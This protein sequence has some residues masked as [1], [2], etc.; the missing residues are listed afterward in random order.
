MALA[1][2]QPTHVPAWKKLGLKLKN[3]REEA[4]G[5]LK[6]SGKGEAD[7]TERNQASIT[8][9]NGG[10]EKIETNGKKRKASKLVG[11]AE[12]VNISEEGP[13]NKAKR[14]KKTGVEKISIEEEG[15]GSSNTAAPVKSADIDVPEI[16]SKKPKRKSVSFA[17]DAKAE[18]GESVGQIYGEWVTAQRASDPDFNAQ[19]LNPALKPISPTPPSIN[20]QQAESTPI[21]TPTSDQSTVT[22]KP[23]KKKKKKKK[24]KTAPTKPSHPPPLP[25]L[26][27]LS[28]NHQQTPPNSHP[29][30]PHLP[31]NPPHHPHPLEIQQSP[32]KPPHQTP[33]PPRQPPPP[34]DLPLAHYLRGLA[35][36]NTRARIRRDALAIR[37][38]DDDWLATL[39]TEPPSVSELASPSPNSTATTNHNDNHPPNPEMH[40]SHADH[41]ITHLLTTYLSALSQ[42]RSTL[43]TQ[44][45][46]REAHDWAS[47]PFI[48][49]RAE[50]E[51]RL[52]RRRRAEVVLWGVGEVGEQ[53]MSEL[54]RA[55][56]EEVVGNGE[57]NGGN[58]GKVEEQPSYRREMGPKR[59]KFSDS[60]PPS[61]SLTPTLTPTTTTTTTTHP[62]PPPTPSQPN[63]PNSETNRKRKRKRPLKNRAGAIPDDETSSSSGTDSEAERREGEE[64][65]RRVER[66]KV[67]R[68]RLEGE[69]R[70]LER[71]RA[72]VEGGVSSDSDSSGGDGEGGGSEGGG[73]ESESENGD[74]DGGTSGE[75]ESE[76]GSE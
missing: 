74:E 76:G 36:E 48:G 46:R 37:T 69:R 45:D 23:P 13:A 35:S 8:L 50:F 56:G 68:E 24:T 75:S 72:E 47:S 43:E 11:G 12:A 27:H 20:P 59:I 6:N 58:E 64:E 53:V 54:R 9:G 2:A 63:P 51:D 31:N 19:T 57:G 71:M 7:E 67:L 40:P 1:A 66:K 22:T 3:G 39:P 73:S 38:E 30:S 33:F 49:G 61:S 29:P 15:V 25:L 16:A 62:P 44:E 26:H 32:P 28:P 52:F 42:I 17:S 65:R 21:E 55:V 70:E 14:E 10:V 4:S 18:D 5:G 34:Y 41:T 60:A